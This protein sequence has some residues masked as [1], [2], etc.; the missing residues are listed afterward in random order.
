MH[1]LKVKK[2]LPVF[3]DQRKNLLL[4]VVSKIKQQDENCYSQGCIYRKNI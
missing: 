1:L 4:Y 3:M 2:C